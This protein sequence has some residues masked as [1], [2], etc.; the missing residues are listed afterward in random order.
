MAFEYPDRLSL[1]VLNRENPGRKEML[2]LIHQIETLYEGGGR[3]EANVE[4]FLKQRSTEDYAVFQKRKERISYEGHFGQAVK[5]ISDRF[6]TGSIIWPE[7]TS[8]VWEDLRRDVDGCGSTEAEFTRNLFKLFLLHG[9]VFTFA[10]T[11]VTD[12]NQIQNQAQLER[13]QPRGHLVLLTMKNVLEYELDKYGRVSWLKY[14]SVERFQPLEDDPIYIARWKFIDDQSIAVYQAR[15]KVDEETMKV[16]SIDE[17]DERVSAPLKQLIRHNRPVTPVEMLKAEAVEHV[18]NQVYILAKQSLNQASSNYDAGLSTNYIQRTYEKS[19]VDRSD[20]G[21]AAD[22]NGVPEKHGNAVVFEGKLNFAEFSGTS[23]QTIRAELDQLGERIHNIV[24]LSGDSIT[25]T[26]LM[27]SGVSKN[28]D[29]ELEEISL[30]GYGQTILRFYQQSINQLAAALNQ[31][32]PELQG[33]NRFQ[34]ALL[35][36][37]IENLERLMAP[38]VRAVIPPTMLKVLLTKIAEELMPNA[39]ED[40]RNQLALEVATIV[41]SAQSQL[42]AEPSQPQPSNPQ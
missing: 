34:V 38:N 3:L 17:Q 32:E 1:E 33:L 9:L 30:K 36:R 13:A 42:V 29:R 10:D 15:V 26:A 6:A 22:S 14:I 39:S 23:I 35:D 4:E 8:Q 21:S 27:Q 7:T 11:N 5:A 20:L 24:M 16:V 31:P 18:G 12:S 25:R 41:V 19:A 2:E 40:E 28:S 37:L